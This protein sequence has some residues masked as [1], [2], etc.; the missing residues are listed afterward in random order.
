MKLKS[1]NRNVFKEYEAL[2]SEVEASKETID[3]GNLLLEN[4]KYKQSHLKREIKSCKSKR[5]PNIDR[6]ESDMNARLAPSSFSDDMCDVRDSATRAM[7]A[8]FEERKALNDKLAALM[9]EH[10]ELGQSLLRKRKLIDDVP[11]FVQS[12]MQPVLAELRRGLEAGL[13]LE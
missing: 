5:Y 3:K 7:L 4:L 8:D 12:R 1:V 9:V 11:V 6:V 10:A 2:R 13:P